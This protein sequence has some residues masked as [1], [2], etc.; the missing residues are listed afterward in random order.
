ML[1]CPVRFLRTRKVAQSSPA[2]RMTTSSPSFFTR[3]TISS[4]SMRTIRLRVAVGRPFGL[5]GG[6]DVHAEPQQRVPFGLAHAARL[7]GAEREFLSADAPLLSSVPSGQRR[8]ETG[9][10]QCQ[11]HAAALGEVFAPARFQG[12]QRRLDAERLDVFDH[13]CGDS[14]VYV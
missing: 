6:I 4:I 7:R 2:Q 13:F 9:L 14:R 8:F 10:L 12:N 3:T 11:F 5:L 1:P